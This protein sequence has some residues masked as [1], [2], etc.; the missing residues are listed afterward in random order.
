MKSKCVKSLL[1]AKGMILKLKL[2]IPNGNAKLSKTYAIVSH[3]FFWKITYYILFTKLCIWK[4][5]VQRT[6]FFAK[7]VIVKHTI[8]CKMSMKCF[9]KL[10]HSPMEV[11]S[12]DKKKGLNYV[13]PGCKSMCAKVATLDLS[14]GTFSVYLIGCTIFKHNNFMQND[15]GKLPKFNATVPHSISL[16]IQYYIWFTNLCIW[17]V[18]VQRAYFICKRGN[19]ETEDSYTKWQCKAPKNYSTV[20]QRWSLKICINIWSMLIWDAKVS[21]QRPLLLIW[22]LVNFHGGAIFRVEIFA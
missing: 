11:F 6:Y 20:P 1:F 19:F 15:N 18:H 13:G 8:S 3:M 4:V 22:D 21:V 16:E 10:C 9:Q 14:L 12:K 7:G 17:K 5:C 2:F